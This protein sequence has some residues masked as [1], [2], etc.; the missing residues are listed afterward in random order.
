[1]YKKQQT[2]V[3]QVDLKKSKNKQTNKT[4]LPISA[5]FNGLWGCSSITGSEESPRL[6]SW[7]L[8]LYTSLSSFSY[9]LQT[10]I[11]FSSPHFNESNVVVVLLIRPINLF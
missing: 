2:E 9:Q 10:L 5:M 8:L 6:T 7:S 1:M 11:I 4:N 3:N